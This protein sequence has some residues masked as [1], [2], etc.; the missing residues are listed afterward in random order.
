[1]LNEIVIRQWWELFQAWRPDPLV[2]IRILEGNKTYS[3]YFKDVDTLLRE[4]R[5]QGDKGVY[6]TINVVKDACFSRRQ[7]EEILLAKSTTSD[8][9][10]EHRCC[11]FIDLDPERPSDTNATDE[12][13]AKAMERTRMVFKFLRDEG[14]SDPIVADSSNG[15]HLYYRINVPCNKETDQVISDFIDVL[16]MMFSDDDVKLDKANKNRARIAKLIGTTSIKGTSKATNRPQRESKFLS[17][18][19]E[20]KETEFSYIQKIASRL[21]KPEP[22]SYRFGKGHEDFDLEAFIRQHNIGIAKRTYDKS[23][24]EKLILEKCPFCGHGAPDSAIFKMANG[25]YGFLCFHNSCQGL[26]WKHFRLHYDPSAYDRRDYEE[27]QRGRKYNAQVRQEDLKPAVEDGRG[28]KWLTASEIKI[29]SIKD[30]IAIPTGI[31]AMDRKIMGLILGEISIVTGSSG[32]GKS[33]FLNHLILTAVQRNYRVGFW[34]GEMKAGRVLDWIHQMAAGKAHVELVPGTDG[35]YSVP[36]PIRAKINTWLGDRLHIYNNAY[37]QKWSQLR[38]DIEECVKQT[39]ANLILLDN[40]MALTID[41][42]QGENNDRQSAFINDMSDLAKRLNVH[43]LLVCHPRKENVNQLI[44]KESVAGTADLTNRVDSLFLLHRVNRD[45]ERR[46]KEF[47]GPVVVAEMMQYNLVI[48]MNK[49]RT[50]GYQ[51]QLFGL[52]YEQETRRLKNDPAENIVYG[53]D[54]TPVVDDLPEDLPDFL[55]HSDYYNK[56]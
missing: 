12:E 23:G 47:F 16:S 36:G 13:K 29:T 31:P 20:W 35:L 41:N 8:D 46:G 53:W 21:P 54:D 17:I 5:K 14:F 27:F 34:S 40:L 52:Y 51:D 6:A 10:I 25:G 19:K 9:D 26:T 15:G 28:K 56:F 11:L 38:A 30:A 55:S 45:F 4:L 2:E 3:G 24:T 43:I 39:S 44:R 7:C 49:A 33:T 50:A 1:M 18:P 22:V 37:G 42:F 32:A 48:E